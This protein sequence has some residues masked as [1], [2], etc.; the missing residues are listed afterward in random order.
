MSRDGARRGLSGGHF[1][2]VTA[3]AE[4]SDRGIGSTVKTDIDLNGPA[5]ATGTISITLTMTPPVAVQQGDLIGVTRLTGCGGGRTTWTGQNSDGYNVYPGDV[6]GSVSVNAQ[7]H[8]PSVLS[9]VGSGTATEVMRWSLPAVGSTAG[10]YGSTWGAAARSCGL[11]T[12]C[13][14]RIEHES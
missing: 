2:D 8:D 4:S 1:R 3:T 13:P 5:T 11:I 9:I 6:T 14:L 12:A 7:W 10:S